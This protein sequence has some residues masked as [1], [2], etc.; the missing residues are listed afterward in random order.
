MIVGSVW[1]D[2]WMGWKPLAVAG[3]TAGQAGSLVGGVVRHATG[4]V[5]YSA[6]HMRAREV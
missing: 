5:R 3:C 6:V 4:S 1:M 2:G